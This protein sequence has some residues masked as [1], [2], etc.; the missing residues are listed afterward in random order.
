MTLSKGEKIRI[1]IRDN[2]LKTDRDK[3]RFKK[4]VLDLVNDYVMFVL[5]EF[6]ERHMKL[7]KLEK[8][9]LKMFKN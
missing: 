8:Q 6:G 5:D 4:Q 2:P 1:A 3:K 7:E 9:V